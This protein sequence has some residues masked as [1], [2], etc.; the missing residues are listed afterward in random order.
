MTQKLHTLFK[1]NWGFLLFVVILFASR[2]SFA[3]W[4]IVPTGSM[5]PTIVEGDRIF[6]DKMAYRLEVPFTDIEIMQ[7][8]QPARGDIVVFNSKQA[9]TRLV[10][11]LIGVP[12]D[13][14][15]MRNNRLVING[16]ASQYQLEVNS[17]KG[18]ETL[19]G[20]EHLVQFVPV[21][22][23]FD[24][25]DEVTVPDGHYLVLGDNRN[26]SSDSRYI[27][28]VPAI[29]IQGKATKVLVSLDP[30][31]YYLPRSERTLKPLI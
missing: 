9:D 5:Q 17:H 4:Y 16:E 6:V 29:E 12:G 13:R 1:E 21:A 14:V 18:I 23:A 3:D 30:E 10:K 27:G 24:N 11:R 2:S 8:G 28:F 25:F 19:N 26:N 22:E 31:N 15:E 20:V 7:T